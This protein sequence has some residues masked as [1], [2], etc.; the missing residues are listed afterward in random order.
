MRLFFGLNKILLLS[1]LNYIGRLLPRDNKIWLYGGGSDR[2]VDNSKYLF[3]GLSESCTNI[4]HIWLT[5]SAE[6]MF[7]LRSKGFQC[8]RK[9]S[10]KGIYYV[11]RAKVYIYSCYPGD[12]ASFAYSGG[13]FL[14]NLWHGIP[15]KKIEYD[16]KVGPLKKIFHPKDIS[17]V[18]DVYST[19]PAFFR[20]SSS[21]LCPKESFIEI[22]KSA[23]LLEGPDVCLAQYPRTAPFFWNESKLMAHIEKY[24]PSDMKPFVNRCKR[25]ERVWIYMPTWRDANPDFIDEAFPD[26]NELDE[27]CRKQ[28][29][30]FLLKLHIAT[31]MNFDE[32]KWTNIVFVPNHFDV[33]PLLPFT[34]TLLTDYSSVFLDYQLLNKEIVF[35]P[36]DLSDYLSK[37][38]EM[39]FEYEELAI[40]EKVYSFSGLINFLDTDC[41][42]GP[43]DSRSFEKDTYSNENAKISSFIKEK[44]GIFE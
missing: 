15:L 44:I 23:F 27:V 7:F 35:Y 29:I 8:H 34:T 22:F 30:L 20:K 33:Y 42:I 37:S 19:Q 25:F 17:E 1:F 10:L 21:V 14:F 41:K 26:F 4:S 28:N 9:R 2:F 32:N 36:F 16:I 6:D 13:A 38:R 31:N 39:Y 12:I 24:E 3:I 18:L 11:L 5:N 40:G 43:K